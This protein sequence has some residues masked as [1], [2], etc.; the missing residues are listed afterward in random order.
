MKKRNLEELID[1]FLKKTISEADLE[2]LSSL[3]QTDPKVEQLIAENQETFRFLHYVRYKEFK[4]RLRE[5]DQKN[6][7]PPG[8]FPSAIFILLA[9]IPVM[10]IS[11][12]CLLQFYKPQNLAARNFEFFFPEY[13]K[14]T[15]SS[16]QEYDLTLV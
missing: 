4:K 8:H 12:Q 16:L 15:I 11:W 10:V 6:Q 5:F 9:L 2:L 3:R 13:Q 14:D 1:A 7:K